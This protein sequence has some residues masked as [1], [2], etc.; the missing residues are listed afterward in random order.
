M[1]YGELNLDNVQSG[2]RMGSDYKN[3]QNANVP[4]ERE[5]GGEDIKNCFTMQN[6]K[7]KG[8]KSRIDFPD[9]TAVIYK[10]CNGVSFTKVR[11]TEGKWHLKD[12]RNTVVQWNSPEI[13]EYMQEMSRLRREARRK[14][15]PRT[16]WPT[17]K[18]PSTDIITQDFWVTDEAL[19]HRMDYERGG[20]IINDLFLDEKY[21]VQQALE[22]PGLSKSEARMVKPQ[23]AEAFVEKA[24]AIIEKATKA[25][26]NGKQILNLANKIHV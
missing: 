15:L 3:F 22:C 26:L 13:D 1:G 2:Y 16:E 20:V 18:F 23:L 4:Y 7:S 21:F 14:G 10:D 12:Y 17:I 24:N 6:K 8:V 9:G 19:L 25:L 5:C 11:D